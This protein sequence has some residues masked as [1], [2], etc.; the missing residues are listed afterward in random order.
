MNQQEYHK[1]E[2]F[3]DE[4]AHFLACPDPSGN[5]YQDI[6]KIDKIEIWG[7]FTGY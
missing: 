7:P 5:V 3:A 6:Y 1:N 4:Q 2:S